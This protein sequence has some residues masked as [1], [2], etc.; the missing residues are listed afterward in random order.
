MQFKSPAINK[1]YSSSKTSFWLRMS[2]LFIDAYIH[3]VLDRPMVVTD[4]LRDP[5]V[6]LQWCKKGNYKSGFRHCIGEAA[7]IRSRNFTEDERDVIMAFV[8]DVLP[9]FCR[10][11]YHQKGSAPHFHVE[12]VGECRDRANLIACVKNAEAEDWYVA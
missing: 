4:I 11:Q 9:R 12:L 7:D 10:L 2:L 8:K 1:E 6:Q 3:E 5:L